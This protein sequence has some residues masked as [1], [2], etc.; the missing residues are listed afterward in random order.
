MNCPANLYALIVDYL[1][2]REVMTRTSHQR[3]IREVKG[4]CPKGSILGPL[5]WNLVMNEY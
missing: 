2:D 1:T 3:K 4:G 5:F